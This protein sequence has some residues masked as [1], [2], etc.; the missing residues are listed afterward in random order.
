MKMIFLPKV[1]DAVPQFL[2]LFIEGV[3]VLLNLIV[4]LSAYIVISV[5]AVPKATKE[6]EI[7]RKS[8]LFAN[9]DFY[10]NLALLG[11]NIGCEGYLAK[12]KC[13]SK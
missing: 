7:G 9:L 4:A 10:L 1:E 11:F 3:L 2:F 5:L 8:F 13:F 6:R 12:E